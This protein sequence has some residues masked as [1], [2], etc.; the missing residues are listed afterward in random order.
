MPGGFKDLRTAVAHGR[1]LK[2]L[3]DSRALATEVAGKLRDN[4]V[5]EIASTPS[6]LYKDLAAGKGHVIMLT[7]QEGKPII[8]AELNYNPRDNSTTNLTLELENS[9]LTQTT[10]S[11]KLEEGKGK[12]KVTTYFKYDDKRGVVSVLDDEAEVPRIFEGADPKNLIGSTLQGGIPIII[13][14]G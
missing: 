8:G 7:Q 4:D 1:L 13:F 12:D 2:K 9:K 14:P 6:E 11:Y 10:S 5:V 3:N